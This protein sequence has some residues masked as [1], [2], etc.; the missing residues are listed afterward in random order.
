MKPGYWKRTFVN[1]YK[2]ESDT[3]EEY[4]GES[5]CSCTP[6]P[7]TGVGCDKHVCINNATNIECDTSSCPCGEGCR[8][9][10]FASFCY[11]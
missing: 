5:V 9:Q 2:N 1:I 4:A 6:Y 7:R 3:D 8:N 10:Q 11:A